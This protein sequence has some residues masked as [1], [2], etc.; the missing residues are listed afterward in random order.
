MDH[1]WKTDIQY[2]FIIPDSSIFDYK[3]LTQDT[4]KITFQCKSEEDYGSL[5][6]DLSIED[7]SIQYILQLL[8]EEELVLK[9]QTADKSGSIDFLYLKEGNYKIKVIYDHNRNGRWDTGDYLNSIQPEKVQYFQKIIN[10]R[11]NWMTE[12]V[13][14][15]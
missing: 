9:K 8:S 1:Q 12:E 6:L 5:R 10:I 15:F 11:E 4:L 2:Q 7:E 3:D 13:W 14:V